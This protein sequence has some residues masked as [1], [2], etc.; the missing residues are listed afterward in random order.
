MAGFILMMINVSSHN[1]H[2]VIYLYVDE[3]RI[4]EYERELIRLPITTTSTRVQ[5]R[6]IVTCDPNSLSLKLVVPLC[7]PY[8]VT[9]LSE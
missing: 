5:C 8:T 4:Y 9:T 6:I 1:E 7:D 3:K 2:G